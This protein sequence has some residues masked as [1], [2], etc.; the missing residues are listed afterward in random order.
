MKS[1]TLAVQQ[2]FQDRRQYRVPFY[3]RAYV[4]NKEDQWERLASDILHKADARFFGEQPVGHFLGAVVLE[5]QSRQG[6]LGVETLHIIDGQQRLTTLQYALAALAILL[7]S[8]NAAALLSL[9][10]GCQQNSNP[11]TMEDAEIEQHK[12]WPTFRDRQNY[13]LAM[14]A[15]TLAELQESFPNSFTQ[16]GTLKKIGIDHAPALEAIWYFHEQFEQ[17]VSQTPAETSGRRLQLLTEALLRDLNL[18]SITLGPEDDAQIIFETLNGHGAQLHATDLIRNFIFMR[19]DRDGANAG[20]LYDTQWSSFENHFWTEE[21]RRGRLKR[22]RL[23]WFLQTALQAQLLEEVDIGRLY[24]AYRRFAIGGERPVKANDQLKLLTAY[25]ENYRELVLGAGST[26]IAEFGRRVQAWDASTTHALALAIAGSDAA[27]DEQNKMFRDLVSYLV[28]RA[29]CGLTTKNYNKVFVQQLK[30][31]APGEISPDA[32]HR[33]LAS[34]E[35]DASRWPRDDEFR[36]S[37]LEGQ[38]YEGRLDAARTR[39]LL[40]ELETGLRSS[41]SEEP[42]PNGLENLDVDHILPMSWF[43]HWPLQDGKSATY[44][45]VRVALQSIFSETL[46]SPLTEAILRR[47]KLKL[48]IGNLTLLHYGVNRGLK[49]YAFPSKREALFAESN[50]HLNRPMMRAANWDEEQIE[51][52][53]KELFEI[54]KRLWPSPDA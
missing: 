46:R 5:P 16:S 4:W 39:A 8:N 14:R 11:Q 12:L 27:I 32:F 33:S 48:T 7:R 31:F 3:Q 29:V 18:V 23:E 43:E 36:A 41:R 10:E 50:L 44:D 54:A 53:A 17:W 22:P 42:I 34:L 1:E 13:R 26:P 35:G 25:A 40:G 49:H 28:R 19:A 9:V 52:R 24:F 51:M 30:R 6:L 2:V 45:D 38:L 47:E 21:Q 37:W 20:E 15:Q